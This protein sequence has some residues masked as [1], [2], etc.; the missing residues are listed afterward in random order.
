M[1]ARR[2]TGEVSRSRRKCVAALLTVMLAAAQALGAVCAGECVSHSNTFASGIDSNC[3]DEGAALGALGMR[4]VTRDTCAPLARASV[5]TVE[6]LTTSLAS[7]P[8]PVSAAQSVAMARSAHQG[9]VLHARRVDA[10]P[11]PG[12]SLPLRI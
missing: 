2:Y 11:P 6:R 5:A 10:G 3:H 12:V 4:D 1:R 7:A 9:T 8:L